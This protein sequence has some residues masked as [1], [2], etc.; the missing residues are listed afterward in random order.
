MLDSISLK[1]DI[2]SHIH[3]H[4]IKFELMRENNFKIQNPKVRKKL[5][6]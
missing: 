2:Q 6:N 5:F 3:C 4:S 1:I